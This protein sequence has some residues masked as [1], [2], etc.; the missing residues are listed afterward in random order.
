MSELEEL[1][2]HLR[3]MKLATA[4]ADIFREG[5]TERYLVHALEKVADMLEI[6][7]SKERDKKNE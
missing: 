1:R 3:E 2:N 4:S 5:E 6:I 7:I